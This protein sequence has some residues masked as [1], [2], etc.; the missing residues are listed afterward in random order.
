MQTQG[1]RTMASATTLATT[2]TGLCPKPIVVSRQYSTIQQKSQGNNRSSLTTQLLDLADW[3]LSQERKLR[4]RALLAG[5]AHEAQGL[6]ARA[7]E[8]AAGREALLE[9]LGGGER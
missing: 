5:D 3:L 6:R 1:Q 2:D 8:W 7:E 4:R 9:A